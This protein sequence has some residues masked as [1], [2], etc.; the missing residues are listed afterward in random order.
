MKT[1]EVN[2]RGFFLAFF[3]VLYATA[4]LCMPMEPGRSGAS[5]KREDPVG[6]VALQRWRV[7]ASAQLSAL[8]QLKHAPGQTTLARRHAANQLNL[9]FVLILSSHFQRFC[10]DL[11]TE[12]AAHLRRTT[13]D[14]WAASLLHTRLV[15][16][17]KLDVGNPNPGHI[18]ADFARF[19]LRIWDALLTR[20]G[21]AKVWRAQLEQLNVWRN[22]IAHQDLS[23]ASLLDLGGGRVHLRRADVLRW[24]RA[25]DRLATL[26]DA[27]LADFTLGLVGAAPWRVSSQRGVR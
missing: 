8:G 10:R 26:M 25:C 27:V 14:P 22:A 4:R 18:G 19:G 16:A 3:D 21:R 15:E 11:H 9:A 13:Q 24:R 2:P 7:E 6:S 5:P 23:A 20:E 1:P 17:R 12:V